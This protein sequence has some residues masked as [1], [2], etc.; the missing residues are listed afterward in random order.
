MDLK[1]RYQRFA[2]GFRRGQLRQHARGSQPI[3]QR[4]PRGM[5]LTGP[6]PTR[7]G[8]RQG[9]QVSLGF[10]L[11]VGLDLGRTLIAGA[12]NPR[13]SPPQDESSDPTTVCSSFLRFLCWLLCKVPVPAPA[14]CP[15]RTSIAGVSGLWNWGKKCGTLTRCRYSL[16]L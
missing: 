13:P 11:A 8:G 3:L 1:S 12:G 16:G 15:S 7:Q 9:S 5:D 10:G 2:A 14:R 6:V 4:W